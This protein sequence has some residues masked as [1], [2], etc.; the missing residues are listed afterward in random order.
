MSKKT[1]KAALLLWV[2]KIARNYPGVPSPNDFS[3]PWRDGRLFLCIIHAHRPELIDWKSV[4]TSDL[5]ANHNKAFKILE[6]LGV[7]PLLDGSTLFPSS[8]LLVSLF[9]IKFKFILKRKI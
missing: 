9:L 1:G 6:K 3:I 4:N 8:I 5:I 7:F 2:Q